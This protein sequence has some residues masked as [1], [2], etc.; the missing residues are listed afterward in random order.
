MPT[1]WSHCHATHTQRHQFSEKPS[2]SGVIG[3]WHKDNLYLGIN[4]DAN[5]VITWSRNPYAKTPIPGKPSK[6]GLIGVWHEDNLYL[7]NNT[8][9]N[10]DPHPM[11]ID[12]RTRSIRMTPRRQLL[13][14]KSF[15]SSLENHGRE[16]I[17]PTHTHT[18]KVRQTR[19]IDLNCLTY[20]SGYGF[21]YA[22]TRLKINPNGPP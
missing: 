21:I 22:N 16:I 17:S 14:D 3:V 9:G 15:F 19:I 6:S 20:M 13:F 12:L 2:K 18:H 8:I 7:G 4:T 5:L 10:G 1:S 11:N